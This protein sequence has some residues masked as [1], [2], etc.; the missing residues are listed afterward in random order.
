MNIKSIAWYSA[1]ISL[2]VM[3]L[4]L[5]LW[6]SLGVGIIGGH[7]NIANL[8]YLTVL[9][10][11]L[12]VAVRRRF[13]PAGMMWALS[14]TAAGSDHAIGGVCW[15]GAALHWSAEAHFTQWLFCIVVS[16]RRSDVSPG[17]QTVG[18]NLSPVVGR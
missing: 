6:L 13:Q 11:T 1:A 12:V 10:V 16:G 5:L 18:I 2:T 15:L 9:L 3:A 7:G 14:C 17:M 4:V 8:L